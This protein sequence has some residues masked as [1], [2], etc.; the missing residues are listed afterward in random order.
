MI[1]III[2]SETFKIRTSQDGPFSSI[3]KIL[4]TLDLVAVQV[5][6]TMPTNPKALLSGTCWNL[7]NLLQ[8][9]QTHELRRRSPTPLCHLQQF[10]CQAHNEEGPALQAWQL[11]NAS[12]WRFLSVARISQRWCWS[13][14]FDPAGSTKLSVLTKQRL[15]GEQDSADGAASCPAWAMPS[16]QDAQTNLRHLS[17]YQQCGIIYYSCVLM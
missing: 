14:N 1:D 6:S 12:L 10:P 8:P 11:L 16:A 17:A 4:V 5:S 2:K 13:A 15:D 3:A 7:R 9:S